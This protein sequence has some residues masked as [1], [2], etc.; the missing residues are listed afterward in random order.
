MALFGLIQPHRDMARKPD[1]QRHRWRALGVTLTEMILYLSVTMG[2]LVFTISLIQQEA[3]RQ[4]RSLAASDLQMAIEGAQLYVA[5]RYDAMIDEMFAGAT[6]IQDMF[7]RVPMSALFDAGYL[8]RAVAPGQSVLSREF[9]QDLALYARAVRRDAPGVT[10]TPNA[11]DTDNNGQIDDRFVDRRLDNDQLEI[12]ALLIADGE[13]MRN[14][15]I[16]L[17]IARLS[18]QPAAGAVLSVDTPERLV[19]RGVAGAWE[20]DLQAMASAAWNRLPNPA[21]HLI[22][23]VAADAMDQNEGY[24]AAIVALPNFGV[25]TSYGNPRE[26]EQATGLRLCPA[27]ALGTPEYQTCITSNQNAVMTNIVLQGW[28]EDGD[29]FLDGFPGLESV[30]RIR[31]AEPDD[32]RPVPTADPAGT[33]AQADIPT[34]KGLTFLDMRDP[35]QTDSGWVLPTISDA[36]RITM[37]PPTNRDETGT[38]TDLQF[39]TIE[40]AA[41]VTC[42]PAADPVALA[43]GR[44]VLDCAKTTISERLAVDGSGVD[45]QGT[46]TFR[47]NVSVTDSVRLTSDPALGRY[48]EL[49]GDGI[50]VSDGAVSASINLAVSVADMIDMSA[51]SVANLEL[52]NSSGQPYDVTENAM[53]LTQRVT[54]DTDDQGVGVTAPSKPTTCPAGWTAERSLVSVQPALPYNDGTNDFGIVHRISIPDPDADVVKANTIFG[55]A[56]T[57][58]TDP[59]CTQV[60]SCSRNY[61]YLLPW[62]S[63]TEICRQDLVDCGT[64]QLLVATKGPIDTPAG[65]VF[66]F[67][68]G[69]VPVP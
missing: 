11:V 34:I 7:L 5:S 29:G 33:I 46:A 12:E 13:M 27:F 38:T 55:R 69:C 32:L 31:M 18:E 36:T 67:R 44:I 17:G 60:L 3:Q 8:P 14:A 54:A 16:A 2:V 58:T 41:A 25:M 1:A 62:I 35:Y 42:D 57:P 64:G 63:A 43:D 26:V 45:L 22:A 53:L 48:A 52:L 10:A 24:I 4:S 61:D 65:T 47:S 39:S 21:A 28:D 68:V 59:T 66:T 37:L 50:I 19:A 15:G 51:V 40:N 23:D 6:G 56:A 49:R 20:V 30:F 9:G